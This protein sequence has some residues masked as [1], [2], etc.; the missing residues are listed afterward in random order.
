MELTKKVEKII[1]EGQGKSDNQS[2]FNRLQQF[3]KEKLESGVA[4]KPRYT[5]PSI[6]E[7]ERIYY[8]KS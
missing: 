3:Y 5:L 2:D 8:Q 4:I 7:I 1:Q 6:G